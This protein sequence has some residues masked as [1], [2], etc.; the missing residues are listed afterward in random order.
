MS[1]NT[2]ITL[3]PDLSYFQRIFMYYGRPTNS[4]PDNATSP[5][6]HMVV[7]LV[8]ELSVVKISCA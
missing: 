7:C 6:L 3:R 4:L 2:R 5:A 1:S 8:I